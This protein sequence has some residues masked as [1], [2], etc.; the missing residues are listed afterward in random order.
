MFL[1]DEYIKFFHYTDSVSTVKQKLF[2]L[3]SY[4][5]KI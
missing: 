3:K 5:I 2:L 1:E 4:F